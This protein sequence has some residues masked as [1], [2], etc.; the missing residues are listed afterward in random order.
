MSA[1]VLMGL[2]LFVKLRNPTSANVRQR[3]PVSFR[4]AARSLSPKGP[5]RTFQA[6]SPEGNRNGMSVTI[7]E[8][9][10]LAMTPEAIPASTVPGLDGLDV[11]AFGAEGPAAVHLDADSP[12]APRVDEVRE[13]NAWAC[14]RDTLMSVESAC[15]SLSSYTFAGP[16]PGAP[17]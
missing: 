13:G 15:A 9:K 2:T 4:N 16:L 8:G 11:L 17:P 5:S 1:G 7:A 3:I 6:I 12:A 10:K 14:F